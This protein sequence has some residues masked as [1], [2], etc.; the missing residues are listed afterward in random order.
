MS[1][2]IVIC[3]HLSVLGRECLS[4]MHISTSW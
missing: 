1:D 2:E 4:G 3:R